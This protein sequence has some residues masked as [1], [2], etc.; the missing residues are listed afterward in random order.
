[1]ELSIASKCST[2]SA[3][4]CKHHLMA[5]ESSIDRTESFIY[6]TEQ[7]TDTLGSAGITALMLDPEDMYFLAHKFDH[8][9]PDKPK[10]TN[11][12]F[13]PLDRAGT[14]VF[15]SHSTP[16]VHQNPRAGVAEDLDK[17]QAM[18][19]DLVQLAVQSALAQSGK[20]LAHTA[21]PADPASPERGHVSDLDTELRVDDTFDKRAHKDRGHSPGTSPPQ[22]SGGSRV[23]SGDDDMC[24]PIAAPQNVFL[25]A[26][27]SA[28]TVRSSWKHRGQ[29]P[30]VEV[31]D[32]T[33]EHI[34]LG[35]DLHAD[36]TSELEQL[37]MQ[38]DKYRRDN[39]ELV[40]E[41]QFVKRKL[42][43]MEEA[44]D[45]LK[46]EDTHETLVA[47]ESG[48]ADNWDEISKDTVPSMF[49]PFYTKLQVDQV[50]AL[51]D[52][53]K[54]NLIKNFML[55]LLI[56]DLD[57]LPMMSQ[58]LGRFL[59][60]T[61]LFVDAVHEHYYRDEPMRPLVYLRDYNIDIGDG[62][63]ECLLGM[64]ARIRGS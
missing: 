13:R 52:R 35:L 4:D 58:K 3:R 21:L 49:Q 38:V 33:M 27:S 28:D 39:S 64:L 1:M 31:G 6:D 40:N 50:D 41:L 10:Q 34:D 9:L 20:P 57:H 32:L 42:A 15:S 44:N 29:A 19:A 25:S 53:E 12:Q 56:S 11:T 5:T 37:R 59:G 55:T 26:P 16:L 18:L 24:K 54:S 62:L 47:Q 51:T 23:P 61:L 22:S 60:E 46:T 43:A 8:K 48:A 17:F 14:P 2:H 36:A 45:T 30:R 63:A 7:D